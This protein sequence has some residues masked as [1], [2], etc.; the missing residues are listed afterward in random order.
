MTASDP[1]DSAPPDD[2]AVAFALPEEIAQDSDLAA[3]HS[4]LVTRLRREAA[5]LPMNTTQQLL[6]ERIAYNY[7]V[8]RF[9][10]RTGGFSTPAQQK[11]YNTFWLS[12][13]QEFNKLLLANDDKLREALLMEINK[14]VLGGLEII[15]DPEDR[16]SMR[17]YLQEQ[18][19]AIEV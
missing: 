13:T 5:G 4:A 3:L 18:F 19:A 14:I 15:K 17:R 2:L 7:I 1:M 9:K 12:M 11:D 10:E 8:M 16:R 6:L